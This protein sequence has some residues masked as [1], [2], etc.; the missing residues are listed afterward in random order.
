MSNAKELRERCNQ[1]REE[2][3]EE[4]K[5]VLNRYAQ[6]YFSTKPCRA[7]IGNKK[8]KPIPIHKSIFDFERKSIY[9]EGC[10]VWPN[11]SKDQLREELKDLGFVLTENLYFCISIP[12]IQKGKKLTFAQKWMRKINDN[13]SAYCHNQKKLANEVYSIFI[14]DLLS[15]PAEEIKICKEYTLFCNYKY[16][17][18]NP[19]SIKCYSYIKRLMSK[20]RISEFYENGEYKGIIVYH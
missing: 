19:I 17:F 2:R 4:L 11:F 12:P 16:N 14:L 3:R 13:Y 10:L 1:L 9:H 8:C 20:D 18:E 7:V 15:I 5:S 6:E